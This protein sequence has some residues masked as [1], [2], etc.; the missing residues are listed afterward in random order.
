M[1]SAPPLASQKREENLSSIFLILLSSSGL[2]G[3]DNTHDRSEHIAPRAHHSCRVSADSWRLLGRSAI[4]PPRTHQ[5][6]SLAP[7]RFKPSP[8]GNPA[9]SPP[10]PP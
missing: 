4:R 10:D 3:R 2:E 7:R 1:T 5:S 8:C 9:R 6:R